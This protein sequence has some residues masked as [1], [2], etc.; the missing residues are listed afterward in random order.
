MIAQISTGLDEEQHNRLRC[1]AYEWGEDATSGETF[2]SN[3]WETFL[4]LN[5]IVCF[6][7]EI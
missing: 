1:P 6:P 2:H 5:S 7:L 4:K 3:V